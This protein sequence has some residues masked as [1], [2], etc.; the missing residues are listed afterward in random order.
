MNDI[1]RINTFIVAFFDTRYND[2]VLSLSCKGSMNQDTPT[3][4]LA[5]FDLGRPS[6]FKSA[7]VQSTF[8]VGK[9]LSLPNLEQ[10]RFVAN[11]Q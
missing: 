7:L 5:K 4:K 8:P 10:N 3:P 11:E 9:S 6:Y 2:H 1:V